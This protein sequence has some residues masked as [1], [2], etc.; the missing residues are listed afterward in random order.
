ME[1]D[2][3][4]QIIGNLISIFKDQQNK[5]KKEIQALKRELKECREM[6]QNRRR[7]RAERMRDRIR[8]TIQREHEAVLKDWDQALGE[9]GSTP[10]VES[11]IDEKSIINLSNVNEYVFRVLIKRDFNDAV[12]EAYRN[13]TLKRRV[14]VHLVRYFDAAEDADKLNLDDDIMAAAEKLKK[15]EE[16]AA[17]LQKAASLESRGAF[18]LQGRTELEEFFNENVVDIANNRELYARLGVGFPKSFIL[19][20]PP[21][22]GKTFAVERLAEHLGWHTQR[23][24]ASSVGSSLVHATARKIEN[25][26]EEA[27]K[28]APAILIIDEMDAFMPNRATSGEH[29]PH[30]KEEVGSFLKCLQDAEKNQVLVVGMTNIIDTIDPAILRTGRMGTHLRVDMPSLEEVESVMRYALEKV[31]HTDFPLTPYAEKL[32]DHPL[33]DVTH[34]VET[35]ARRTGQARREVLEE[36]DLAAAID[37]MLQR[38]RAREKTGRPIGFAT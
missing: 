36:A 19:E 5:T 17:M 6:E 21:G 18:R 7:A 2:E 16:E 24:S 37:R 22:C 31:P 23:I 26:F 9:P 4:T 1:K 8:A 38:Q 29:H 32:L 11:Y 34:A 35:A 3:F 33:S 12:E 25:A 28:N 15:E 30:V 27:T 20:G 10:D 13:R 14:F